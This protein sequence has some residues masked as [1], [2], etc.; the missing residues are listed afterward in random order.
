MKMLQ[1]EYMDLK[2]LSLYSCLG[3]GTLRDYIRGDGLPSFK[4]RGKVLVRLSEFNK[5]M[6]QFREEPGRLQRVVDEVM[7]SLK[8]DS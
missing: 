7:D 1:P 2:A 8:S 5:W 6:E 4:V 3:V